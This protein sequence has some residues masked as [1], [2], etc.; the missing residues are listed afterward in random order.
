MTNHAK[1]ISPD[2]RDE[3]HHHAQGSI[4]LGLLR[5]TSPNRVE[6]TLTASLADEG[7]RWLRA[8]YDAEI[9]EGVEALP[10]LS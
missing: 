9:Q 2:L 10:A 7:W 5:Q 1:S 4:G 8:H 3:I 6:L